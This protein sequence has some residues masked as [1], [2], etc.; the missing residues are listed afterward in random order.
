MFWNAAQAKARIRLSE[1][2]S[3][4]SSSFVSSICYPLAPSPSA[5]PPM[6][7][8]HAALS[9]AVLWLIPA[10]ALT[11]KTCGALLLP[12]LRTSSLRLTLRRH[13]PHDAVLRHTLPR[14]RGGGPAHRSHCA[15]RHQRSG[16][17]GQDQCAC[18]LHRCARLRDERQPVRHGGLP[19]RTRRSHRALQHH[20]ARRRTAGASAPLLAATSRAVARQGSRERARLGESCAV[21]QQV[22]FRLAR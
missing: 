9:L 8:R 7:P 3:S 13:W 18:F 19:R 14:P 22:S 21:P 15:W 4:I 11:W 16:G 5:Y 12:S 17:V 2:C 10:H 20:P 6:T 1:L